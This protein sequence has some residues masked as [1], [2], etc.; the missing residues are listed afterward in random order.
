MI[1][2][3]IIQ[4]GIALLAKQTYLNESVLIGF[5]VAGA[6][7]TVLSVHWTWL[8]ILLPLMILLNGLSYLGILSIKN[9]KINIAGPRNGTHQPHYPSK[10]QYSRLK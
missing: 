4:Q 7:K 3:E 8:L 10:N 1:R 6:L 2:P 9:K 5:V